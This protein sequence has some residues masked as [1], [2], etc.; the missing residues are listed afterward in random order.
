MIEALDDTYIFV[1]ENVPRGSII[2]TLS[3]LDPDVIDS[4]TYL[5]VEGE[6]SE[7]NELF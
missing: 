1:D 5:L 2:G 4:F 7:D 6:G 3:T